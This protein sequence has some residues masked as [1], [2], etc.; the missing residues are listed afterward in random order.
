[1]AHRSY[2]KVGFDH[3]FITLRCNENLKKINHIEDA[4]KNYFAY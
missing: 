1:M 4:K 3:N 2:P